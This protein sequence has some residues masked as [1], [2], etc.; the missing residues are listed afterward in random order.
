MK[1]QDGIFA[2]L[3][4]LYVWLGDAACDM[5][6]AGTGTRYLVLEPKW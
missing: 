1:L 4:R 5:E 3:C 2:R 6:L